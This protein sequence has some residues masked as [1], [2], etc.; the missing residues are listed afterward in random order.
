MN[1]SRILTN[2]EPN[3]RQLC[4]TVTDALNKL[5]M[6]YLSTPFSGG[7]LH[8]FLRLQLTSH[9]FNSITVINLASQLLDNK[10]KVEEIKGGD[11]YLPDFS[12]ND[13]SGYPE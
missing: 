3:F 6:I 4:C 1:L 8:S 12:Q 2:F 10:Y 13:S 11:D 7:V 9:N 5:A